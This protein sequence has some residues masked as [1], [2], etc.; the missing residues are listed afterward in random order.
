VVLED[1]LWR[2]SC[3]GLHWV[4]PLGRYAGMLTAFA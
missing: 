3:S 4:I 2:A 1:L